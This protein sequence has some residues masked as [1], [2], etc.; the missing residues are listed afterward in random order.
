MSY[1]QPEKK[2]KDHSIYLHKEGVYWFKGREMRFPL[3][4]LDLYLI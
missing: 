1:Y 4:K 2:L 3:K